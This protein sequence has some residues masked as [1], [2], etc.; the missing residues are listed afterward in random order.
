M[1]R[2]FNYLKKVSPKKT[3]MMKLKNELWEQ[4]LN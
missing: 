2:M 4:L 3:P 1:E